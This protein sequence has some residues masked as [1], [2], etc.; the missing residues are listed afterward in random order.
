MSKSLFLKK[1]SRLLNG[2]PLVVAVVTEKFFN[3]PSFINRLKKEVF[4]DVLELRLDSFSFIHGN[5]HAAILLSQ[6]I[7]KKIKTN[8]RLPLLLTLRSYKECGVILPIEK[9]LSNEKREIF[10]TALLSRVDLV[11]LEIRE[12]SFSQAMTQLAKKKGVA[13]IHSAHNFK[14]VGSLKDIN[15]LVKKSLQFN[16]DIFKVAVTPKNQTEL[17]NFLTWGKQLVHPHPV[18]IAMGKEGAPSRSIGYSFGSIFTYGHLGKASAPG[19][20]SSENLFSFTKEVYR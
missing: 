2:R 14:N 5:T 8:S 7:I 4:A 17:F 6:F 19:Q 3:E 9:R 12:T 1:Y 18:F 20:F 10:L 15:S 11:D 16:G 13:V